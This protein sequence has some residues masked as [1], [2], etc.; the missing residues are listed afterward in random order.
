MAEYDAELNKD[1]GNRRTSSEW[2]EVNAQWVQP[3]RMVGGTS[4]E[5]VFGEIDDAA[6]SDPATPATM[7]ARLAAIAGALRVSALAMLKA[8]DAAHASGDVGVALLAVRRD[9]PGT[10][11]GADNAYTNF[12]VDSLGR[13]RTILGGVPNVPVGVTPSAHS[14]GNVAAAAAVATLPG[15]ASKTTYITGFTITGAGATA[16]GVIAVT[17]T[18]LAA[19]TLTFIMAI[20]AGVTAPVEPLVVTFPTPLPASAVNTAIVVTAP[21]FGAGNTNAAATAVGF[22]V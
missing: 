11:I 18:G 16:A 10:G 15:V 1:V 7:M 3:V 12:A 5:D 6:V 22:N 8:E 20:P 14:S 19:G 4:G 17:V 9:T 13:L 2:D 21:S